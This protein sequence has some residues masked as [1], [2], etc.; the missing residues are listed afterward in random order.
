MQPTQRTPLLLVSV[1]EY[2]KNK[3]QLLAREA[4]SFAGFL[5]YCFSGICV[6]PVV[7]SSLYLSSPSQLRSKNEPTQRTP[8]LSVTVD[9]Y[10]RWR[11]FYQ[12]ISLFVQLAR[13]DVPNA[14]VV[15]C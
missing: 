14:G 12:K 6:S 9:E 1:E 7:V 2:D 13:G 11:V 15:V 8:L 5:P 4:G 10:A 3:N